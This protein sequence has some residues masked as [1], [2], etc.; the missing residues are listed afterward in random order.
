MV[1]EKYAAIAVIVIAVVVV[2]A[3]AGFLITSAN[4]SNKCE[5]C[6]MNNCKM[7]HSANGT[8]NSSN[9]HNMSSE[10]MK[11]MNMSN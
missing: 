8:N 1:N 9:M 4:E 6:G 5:V 3:A 11:N 2:G 7:D 10:D